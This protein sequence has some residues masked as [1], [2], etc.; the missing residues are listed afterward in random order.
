VRHPAARSGHAS[1]HAH[2]SNDLGPW[3]GFAPPRKLQGTLIVRNRLQFHHH[4]PGNTDP[5]K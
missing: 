4:H 5:K 3:L 1:I 2:L